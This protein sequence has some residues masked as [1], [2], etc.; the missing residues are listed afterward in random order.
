L[1]LGELTAASE[2]KMKPT[3]DWWWRELNSGNESAVIVKI[4]TRLSF[5]SFSL[6]VEFIY[7]KYPLNLII[8]V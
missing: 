4:M 8:I 7:E 6:L 1:G 3:M 2:E 5:D